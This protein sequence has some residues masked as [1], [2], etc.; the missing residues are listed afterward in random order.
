MARS[1]RIRPVIRRGQAVDA[2]VEDGALTISMK[3][4]A[5]EDG[6]PGQFIRVRNAQS[7][8]DIRGKVVNEHSIL[9][10]L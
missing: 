5:L 10:S 8:R 4:E 3:V 1:V 6:A 2:L 7:L 9:V